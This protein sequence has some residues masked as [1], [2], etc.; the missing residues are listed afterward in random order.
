M[1]EFKVV[2][3]LDLLKATL[4]NRCRLA[5]NDCWEWV[6]AKDGFYGIIW[7]DG[8]T[9][10]AHR[11]SYECYHGPIPTGLHVLHAC[12]N[13][14]CI[15][16]DHLSVG[17]VKENMAQRDSRGRGHDMRGEQI[18]TSKLTA[19]QVLEIKASDLSVKELSEKYGVHA[20]NIWLIRTG[21]S[22]KHLNAPEGVK[23]GH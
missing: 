12:D 17:T 19:E 4:F 7:R 8:K 9:K 23:H 18:G 2:T 5:E 14:S 1:T 22:W 15:N 3:D 16:P 11:V 20:T 21:K 10:K 6:G 13:P